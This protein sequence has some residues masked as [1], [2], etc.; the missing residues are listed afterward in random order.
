MKNNI[1]KNWLEKDLHEY[2]KNMFLHKTPHF[3]NQKSFSQEDETCFYITEFNLEN[4]I[5]DYLQFKISKMID[6]PLIFH[7]IYLNVQHP[8]MNGTFH[9]DDG[10]LTF[11]YIHFLH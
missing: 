9:I 3:F 4:K 7:R 1:Y 2:L 11:I 10:T 8:G 6:K 5:I